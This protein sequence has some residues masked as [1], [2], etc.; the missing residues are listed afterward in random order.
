MRTYTEAMAEQFTNNSPH[1]VTVTD[2]GGTQENP[3]EK[4]R[5]GREYTKDAVY[6]S[7]PTNT[8]PN[9]ISG[10]KPVKQKQFDG[11]TMSTELSESTWSLYFMENTQ[12]LRTQMAGFHGTVVFQEIKKCREDRYRCDAK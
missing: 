8:L 1:S 4:V 9:V 10:R 3:K 6:I 11:D 2:A 7:P 12:K 5:R